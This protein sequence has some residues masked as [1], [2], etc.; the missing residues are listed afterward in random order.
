VPLSTA[1]P[2]KVDPEG[3]EM[4]EMANFADLDA[5]TAE[6]KWILQNLTV[7]VKDARNSISCKQIERNRRNLG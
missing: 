7:V 4:S 1:E 2:I 6:R 5:K 3:E